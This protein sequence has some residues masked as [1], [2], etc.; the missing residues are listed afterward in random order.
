MFR[1]RFNDDYYCQSIENFEGKNASFRYWTAFMEWLGILAVPVIII[2]ICEAGYS[3]QRWLI[4]IAIASV[5]LQIFLFLSEINENIRYIRHQL[6]TQ[7]EAVAYVRKEL[8]SYKNEA[9]FDLASALHSLDE[10]WE[11]PYS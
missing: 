7:R 1:P 10:K 6:R 4:L 11:N 9:N 5:F 3:W 8:F 2:G